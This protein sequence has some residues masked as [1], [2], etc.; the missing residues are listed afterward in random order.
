MLA[1]APQAESRGQI[2][3]CGACSTRFACSGFDFAEE[4]GRGGA[5]NDQCL[6]TKESGNL[7]AET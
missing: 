1:E 7:K 3:E 6:M 5:A 4:G 2:T